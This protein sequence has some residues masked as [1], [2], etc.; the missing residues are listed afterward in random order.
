MPDEGTQQPPAPTPPPPP[1]L[2]AWVRAVR[3]AVP[4][5]VTAVLG[6]EGGDGEADVPTL[7]VLP[8]AWVAVA[9][10]LKTQGF[11]YFADLAAVDHPERTAR[12]E[13][14][15]HLRDLATQR[16]VRCSTEVGDGQALE[17]LEPLFGGAGWPE[18]EIYDLFGTPFRGNADLRRL[19]LPE[20]WSGHPLR[21]D[22][23]LT[24]P[25]ALDPESPYAH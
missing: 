13:I 8:A 6:L 3:A 19:L 17:S 14:V 11:D 16:L 4:D 2:P 25:R 10:A 9:A 5:A 1:Q 15:L 20:D 22:Y 24:G 21:R 12:L 18:R 23:P 7:Q